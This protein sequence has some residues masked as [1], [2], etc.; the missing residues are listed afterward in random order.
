MFAQGESPLEE[1]SLGFCLY[2]SC[3]YFEC[4]SWAVCPWYSLYIFN[5]FDKALFWGRQ[6]IY[7]HVVLFASIHLLIGFPFETPV[8]KK[9]SPEYIYVYIYIYV[10]Q[11]VGRTADKRRTDS[12]QRTDGGQRID[13]EHFL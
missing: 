7:K 8:L 5:S 13:G 1:E 10:G 6:V 3:L 4:S 11:T 9:V 12:G 2:L